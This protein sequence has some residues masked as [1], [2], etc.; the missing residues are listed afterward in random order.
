MTGR[1]HPNQMNHLGI[2]AVSSGPHYLP[3]RLREC[4]KVLLIIAIVSLEELEFLVRL[5]D[6]IRFHL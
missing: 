6:L 1:I 4:S 2:K 3:Y 5:A